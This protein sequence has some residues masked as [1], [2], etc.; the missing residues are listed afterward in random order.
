MRPSLT[1]F[2]GIRQERLFSCPTRHHHTSVVIN[3]NVIDVSCVAREKPWP[4][5]LP[6]GDPHLRRQLAFQKLNGVLSP[7]DEATNSN[8]R[9]TSGVG[10]PCTMSDP[11]RRSIS[12]L[13]DQ[14]TVPCNNNLHLSHSNNLV[15]QFVQHLASLISGQKKVHSTKRNTC[16]VGTARS[17]REKGSTH[18]NRNHLC[19]DCGRGHC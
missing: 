5:L 11:C 13:C 19:T 15:Q 12:V 2:P 1:F 3:C 4:T 6:Q 8:Q 7:P 10:L 17:C 16:T 9:A 14:T 18:H